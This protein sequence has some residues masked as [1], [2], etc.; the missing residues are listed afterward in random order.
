M[1]KK[2]RRLYEQFQP[3]NYQL[4]MTLDRGAMSFSGR[5][6]IKGK[7]IGRPAERL[8]FHQ[9]SLKITSAAITKHD[10]KGDSE[11]SVKRINNQDSFD[12]IRLHTDG[13][14]Y[15]GEYT[16]VMEFEGKIVSGMNGIYPCPF[17]HDGQE[18]MLI[19]TQFESHYARKAFPCIDEPAAKATFDLTLTTPKG[20]TALSNTPVKQQKDEGKNTVFT[21]ETTPRMSTYLLAFVV[22]EM[23]AKSAKTKN[24]TEVKA[25]ATV[26]QPKDSL[27]FAVEVSKGCIEFFEDYFGVPYPLPKL[28]NVALPDFAVGA[29]ENWGL[30]TYRE[31]L[32]V[33]YPG[34]TSQAV[35]ESIALVV[36]H[37]TSHQWFGDLTTM[38]WWDDL[39]LN[40]SFANMM[41]YQ[42]VD[43]LFPEWNVWEMFINYEGLLAFRRDA[44]PGVQAV[45]T[46]VNHPDEISTIFDPSIVY[47]KG[48]RLLYMLKNYIGEEAFRKGLALYF[49]EH[50]YKNT[51]GSDLWKAL[52]EASGIDVQAFMNP[53]LTR[54]GFPM[55]SI[56]QEGKNIQIDQKQFLDNP[57]KAD[58]ERLW[59]VPLFASEK[60]G[61]DIITKRAL[62]FTAA[63]DDTLL[64]NTGARG[65]YIVRYA[66]DAQKNAAIGMIKD[67][68]L[69]TVDRLMLLSSGSMLSRAGYQPYG[70]VLAML[71]AYGQESSEPVWEIIAVILGETKRFVDLDKSLDDKI[72][73]LTRNLIAHEYKRLGWKEKEGESVADRKLR[74]TI[75]GL[76]AYA[77]EPDIIEKAKELFAKYQKNPSAVP[78][79]L[80]SIVFSVAVKEKI[81]G[82][83][84]Y[85]LK[86]HDKTDNSDLKAD[87]A[88]SLTATR[89][90]AETEKLLARLTDAKLVKSQDADR[91]VI[92]LLRNR[93][94]KDIAWQW[95][96][97][98]W[99]W[100]ED[101]Y[102]DEATYDGWPRYAASICNTEK[103]LERYKAFFIPKQTQIALKRNIEIGIEEINNRI[104]WLGRDLESVQKFFI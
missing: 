101:T 51:T 104:E 58:P 11:L 86:L 91:W 89:S 6:T 47:A 29:M 27:D 97:E 33:A 7:K 62:E 85:L 12:E 72:K 78:A 38:E 60:T 34:Q 56:T 83:F 80:R 26:A 48:G 102:K 17:V 52:G 64:L 96:E 19:A 54:S 40:E 1:S 5:V 30:L 24:G 16:V 4:E 18:K 98:N 66:T 9:K 103:W 37:E 59:P 21:F 13:M 99:Q 50:A 53:W 92:Y 84:D 42:A 36:A 90:I 31:R 77:K 81:A 70:D 93:H 82:A 69:D 41:E 61:E 32:L 44:T 3:E 49:T 45:K 88:G 43:S 74:A 100:I 10:K 71:E 55:L 25:W 65:H 94:T 73:Q 95:M 14:A 39:W 2:V 35:K 75:I 67:G 20:E 87:V 23:H 28:D 76:G 15:P 79:E 46:E 22:G 8:T 68:Q 57:K 63:S